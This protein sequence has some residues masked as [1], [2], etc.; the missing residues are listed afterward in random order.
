[1]SLQTSFAH[2]LKP[3]P[4][5]A[6]PVFDMR[7]AVEALELDEDTILSLVEDGALSHAWD[8]GLGER[9]MELRILAASVGHYLVHGSK[10]F[11]LSDEEVFA[12]LLPPGPARPFLS[13]AQLQRRLKCFGETIL[14]LIKAG[15]LEATGPIPMGQIG[16][17]ITAESFKR[18]IKAR[19]I[20]NLKSQISNSKA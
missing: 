7:G 8:I 19:R 5:V 17:T 14:R 20:S 15:E 11:P 10:P 3:S 16:A 13:N 12:L 18:F 9:R 6:C 4:V 1:M 2:A